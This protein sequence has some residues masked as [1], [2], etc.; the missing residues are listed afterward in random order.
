MTKKSDFARALG[1]A[2]GIEAGR[3]AGIL[4]CELA[5]G[6]PW[7]PEEPELPRRLIRE[8]EFVWNA[9]YDNG[10]EIL[11]AFDLSDLISANLDSH[12]YRVLHE[13][14]AA[15]N[16]EREEQALEA[17]HG[18]AI[19]A[20]LDRICREEI[21]AEVQAG[22]ARA[23]L[24]VYTY[25][26]G[27]GG[28]RTV[29]EFQDAIHAHMVKLSGC[30]EIDGA[31][32]DG[33]EIEFTLSEI[34]QAWAAREDQAVAEPL[35]Q[36][37]QTER[38]RCLSILDWLMASFPAG[39]DNARRMTQ[40][41]AE[42]VKSGVLLGTRETAIQREGHPPDAGVPESAG[43][44][45]RDRLMQNIL[46]ERDAF[47]RM[48]E[49]TAARLKNS[50]VATSPIGRELLA[51]LGEEELS[52]PE[53]IKGKLEDPDQFT[54]DFG[55]APE[56]CC[57]RAGCRQ[58]C[59]Y[60]CECQQCLRSYAADP[61]LSPA[62]SVAPAENPAAPFAWTGADDLPNPEPAEEPAAAL[63]FP[64][65]IM[66]A[67]DGTLAVAY[68]GRVGGY[69]CRRLSAQESLEAVRRWGQ[70]PR[71]RQALADAAAVIR[72]RYPETCAEIDR[73]EPFSP[74]AGHQLRVIVDAYRL[75]T[76]KEG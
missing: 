51:L 68:K 69:G 46:D 7:D 56:R 12:P 42:K 2:L 53:W 40:A 65:S 29:R 49:S 47:V 27:E 5:G 76:G 74:P 23:A 59:S 48:V 24:P 55:V 10:D 38:L 52:P 70:E 3:V 13:A 20:A 21:D 31:G 11:G 57:A 44:D 17:E 45:P 19:D 8:R 50:A 61:G 16:R 64:Q 1:K 34:S 41:A 6:I 25:R 63:A 75:L 58:P 26:D 71:L 36:V 15:Y 37:E 22:V 67:D 33:D 4:D 30:Q 14:I 39:W 9:V 54:P 72:A 60:P 32:S 35:A 18:A 28:L 43:D 66:V 62:R 73:G